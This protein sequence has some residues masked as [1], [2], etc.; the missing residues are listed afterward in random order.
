M[1][2]TEKEGGR[3]INLL[4]EISKQSCGM[5]ISGCI[6]SDLPRKPGGRD[7]CE[8]LISSKGSTCKVE[9]KETMIAEKLGLKKSQVVCIEI[10]RETGLTNDRI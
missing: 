6:W 7:T 10:K 3:V 1:W 8:K 5:V 4:E 2:K 9:S